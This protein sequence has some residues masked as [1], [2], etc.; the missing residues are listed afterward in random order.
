MKKFTANLKKI[1][2]TFI[3][4]AD[5]FKVKKKGKFTFVEMFD[6]S[7]QNFGFI[8]RLS[9]FSRLVSPPPVAVT[10]LTTVAIYD[11]TKTPKPRKHI[12][13]VVSYFCKASSSEH[14]L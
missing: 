11:S 1:V 6:E 3:E 13:T 4:F 10:C 5:Y 8:S 12:E 7:F 14:V 9:S 2:F